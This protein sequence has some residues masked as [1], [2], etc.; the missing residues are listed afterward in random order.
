M[1][2]QYNGL[3]IENYAVK[4]YYHGERTGYIDPFDS[5]GKEKI[6]I[7]IKTKKTEK[8]TQRTKIELGSF[9]RLPKT[10]DFVLDIF[11]YGRSNT[12]YCRKIFKIDA[13]KWNANISKEMLQ[14]LDYQRVFGSISNRHED[15]QKWTDRRKSI[16]E[17]YEALGSI[18]TPLFKRDHKKQKRI[19]AST[20]LNDILEMSKDCKT[21]YL[22]LNLE[23][24]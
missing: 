21:E 1:E 14:L 23:D 11:F 10:K 8:I 22:N 12:I 19:Q 20:T 24:I 4:T 13:K 6:P 9:R 3:K 17:Q 5:F 18:F 7:Q 15:D 2:R 16:K